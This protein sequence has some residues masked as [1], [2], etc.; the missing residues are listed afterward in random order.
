MINIVHLANIF[1]KNKLNSSWQAP[2][3]KKIAEKTLLSMATMLERGF[4]LFWHDLLSSLVM[5]LV[6]PTLFFNMLKH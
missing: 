6:I 1:L 2:K 5:P 4:A 3:Y